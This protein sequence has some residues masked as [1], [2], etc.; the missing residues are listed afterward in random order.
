[1]LLR[2][3]YVTDVQGMNNC[4]QNTIVVCYCSLTL[5]QRTILGHDHDK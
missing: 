2:T 4:V 5:L 3:T 1:M